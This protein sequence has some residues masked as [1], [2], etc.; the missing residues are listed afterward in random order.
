MLLT[1][2]DGNLVLYKAGGIAL[3][4]SGLNVPGAKRPPYYLSMD[5][6]GNLR[7]FGNAKYLLNN[8]LLWASNSGGR[9]TAPYK[10]TVLDNGNLVLNDAKEAMVWETGTVQPKC[11]MCPANFTLNGMG[12]D[13]ATF[14]YGKSCLSNC[15]TGWAVSVAGALSFADVYC[16]KPFP[17]KGRGVGVISQAMCTSKAG[18]DGCEKCLGLWYAKCPVG[19]KAA[20]CNLCTQVCPQGTIDRGNN[21]ERAIAVPTQGFC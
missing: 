20:G 6:D 16:V 19:Y 21:C 15:P 17:T 2:G 10:L 4:A 9:G 12:H 8:G 18:M 3:W 14:V 7:T 1:S 5:A 11:D 13:N